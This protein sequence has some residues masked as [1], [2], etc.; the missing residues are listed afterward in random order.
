MSDLFSRVT[1]DQDIIK[2]IIGKIPGFSG[3][4]DKQNR[5]AAD[6]MLR[7]TVA[8]RFEEQWKRISGI[9]RDLVNNQQI[10][11]VDDVE[12]A[13]IKLRQFIDRIKNASYGYSSFFDNVKVDNEELSAVY[14]YDL[15]LL[16][17]SDAVSSA[18]DN[19]ETSIGSDGMPAAIRNLVTIAQ[20][21]VDVFNR[22]G[23]V[24]KGGEV[25]AQSQ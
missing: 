17:K 21:C 10:E 5:K 22:R 4:F 8:S 19:A 14:Q 11:L 2:K 15:T 25:T 13:S 18:V 3:Y 23:E 20:D 1:A 6:K 12:Q 24:L 16:E 7:E 9:Q